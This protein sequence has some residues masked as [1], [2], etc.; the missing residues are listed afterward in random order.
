[1]NDILIDQLDES[2]SA[3]LAGRGRMQGSNSQLS[4][5]IEIAD[6]LRCLPHPGFRTDLRS[7]LLAEATL[8]AAEGSNARVSTSER[9]LRGRSGLKPGGP[10]DS[11][12]PPLFSTGSSAMPVRGSHLAISFALHVVAT[13]LVFASGWLVVEN[14]AALRAP[15]VQLVP[16][17]TEDLLPV[18]PGKIGGGGGGGDRDKMDASHGSPPRFAAEQLA[19]PAV[20]VRNEDPKL[21]AEPT[22]IGPPDLVLPQADK[23]G[24]PMANILN[25]PSNGTGS[26]GGIGSGR[27][28]GIGSGEGPGVGEGRG[29]GIGGGV[30][31]VGGGVSAPRPIYDPDPE[32]S[33]EARKAKY[34]GIVMLSAIIGSDGRPRELR[35]VRSLGMGLDQKALDAVGKWR[36]AP[37]TK[38]NHP[39]SVQVNIEVAFRLY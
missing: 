32:Y 33:E 26:G 11:I 18:A 34:Q 12:V 25:P 38:D 19:P 4:A 37:A 7:D 1:M 30:Y 23:Y 15:V 16:G 35:I 17:P 24:D 36:F 14:R 21:T 13:A 10:R 5:L 27:G 29:G 8:A 31:R 28:G 9:E 6:E 3:L 39:V 2:I 20:V 22:V